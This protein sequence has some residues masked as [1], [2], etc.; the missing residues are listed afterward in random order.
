VLRSRVTL[1]AVAVWLGALFPAAASAQEW[2]LHGFA[3]TNWSVRTTGL[4]DPRLQSGD[5]LLGEERLQLE[6]KG[7]STSGSA[8]FLVKTD[9]FHDALDGR[10][11]LEVREAYVDAVIGPVGVRVGRQIITRGIGDLLFVNDVFPKDYTA[12]FSGRPI[13]YLKLGLDALKVDLAA[14]NGGIELVLAPSFEPDRVPGPDRFVL[15]DPFPD[16]PRVEERP[17]LAL[18]DAQ[19]AFRAYASVAGIDV[20]GYGYRGFYGSASPRPDGGAPATRVLL[21]FPRLDVYGL[22]LQRAGIGGVV[23]AELGYYDSRE[24][25]AGSDPWTPNSE[26]RALIGYQTQPWAEASV[27]V[28][29][30]A[31]WMQHHAAYRE[32]L[33]E[34][35]TPRDELRQVATLRY[36]QLLAYQTWQLSLFAFVGLSESDYLMIPEVRHRLTD[37]LWI[38]LGANVFGGGRQDLFGAMDANDNVYVTARYGF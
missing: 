20:A 35:M 23:G 1:V 28:Q 16:V 10:A 30:Y 32:S 25:A 6:L 33:P 4:S 34:A 11:D 5:Y 21:R 17:G 15:P 19:A 29:Y 3:Q 13:Q 22:S 18:S 37:E 24:D 14:G 38:A 27:G 26:L 8:G 31:E 7:Y 9:L 36:T 12:F 2:P